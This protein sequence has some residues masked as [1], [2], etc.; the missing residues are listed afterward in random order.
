LIRVLKTERYRQKFAAMTS[1]SVNRRG[2]LRWSEFERIKAPCPERDEQSAIADILD[3]ATREIDALTRLREAVA[4]QKRG[5]MQQ[6]LAGRLRVPEEV[7][8]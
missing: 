7:N 2:G 4:K 3:A 8:R 5:L 1:G 6:L